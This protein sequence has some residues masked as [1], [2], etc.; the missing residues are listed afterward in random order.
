LQKIV[1]EHQHQHGKGKKAQI[2]EKARATWIALHVAHRVDVQQ[3]ADTVQDEF[4]DVYFAVDAVS[5]MVGMP[6]RFDDWG[7]DILLASVQKAWALPPGFSICIVRDRVLKRSSSVT[8]KGYYFDFIAWEKKASKGQTI[9]TPSIPHMYGLKKQIERIR[10]E[11]LASRFDRYRAMAKATRA[12]AQTMGLTMFSEAGFHSDTV[13]CIRNDV[14][15]DLEHLGRDL[16]DRGYQ[17]SN[18]YGRLKNQTFRIPHMGETTP[19][20]L[21]AYLKLISDLAIKK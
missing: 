18:G 3:Q 11:G 7:I 1:A 10:S 15:W 5:S 19:E 9:V 6:I 8:Q 17:F 16:M 12:W 4:P 21:S 13:S 14:G 2:G 20:I